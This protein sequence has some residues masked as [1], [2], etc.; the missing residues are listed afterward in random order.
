MDGSFNPEILYFVSKSC[1]TRWHLPRERIGFFDLTFI[2]R[3]EA[4][5]TA[6][7]IPYVCK[8]GD[9]VF[10][11]AGHFRQAQTKGMA[12]CAFNFSLESTEKLPLATLVEWQQ[13]PSISGLLKN[14]NR[15]WIAK[16][17][18]SDLKCKV[19]FLDILITLLRKQSSPNTNSHVEIMKKY[20]LDHLQ[21]TCSMEQ[22]AE[23]AGLNSVYCGALFKESTGLTVSAYRNQMRINMASTLLEHETL[24]I[25]EIAYQT[26]FEDVY[27]F[28]R[29]F[30]QIKGISP[31]GFRKSMR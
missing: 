16:A 21:E 2:T 27:Y 17:P 8:A 3:G 30:K 18:Y 5:Y 20:I 6:D 1:D 24:N 29:V 14:F 26:G 22:L 25:S 28:S 11:P 23:A 7:D 12:C 4:V 10:I 19:I 13:L 31:L 15:E 9:A